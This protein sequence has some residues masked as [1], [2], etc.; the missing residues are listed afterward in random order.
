MSTDVKG[1]QTSCGHHFCTSCIKRLKILLV[2]TV[3]LHVLL[4]ESSLILIGS[5]LV[6]D[7]KCIAVIRKMAACTW[8]GELKNL[9]GTGKI[10]QNPMLLLLRK[11]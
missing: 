7:Y 8:K 9:S 1:S 6:V 11:M 10:V 4:T 5:I 3:E 2:Q